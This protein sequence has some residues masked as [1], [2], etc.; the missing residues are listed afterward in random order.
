MDMIPEMN[1]HI[2][3]SKFMLP[4]CKAVASHT[5]LYKKKKKRLE[6]W[7][8][9]EAGLNLMGR[10]QITVF[11]P[12]D[13]NNT[14]TLVCPLDWRRYTVRSKPQHLALNCNSSL[15]AVID[16]SGVLTVLD[17]E[18]K[19]SDRSVWSLCEF[20]FDRSRV[21]PQKIQ[22]VGVIHVLEY[23]IGTLSS[24]KDLCETNNACCRPQPHSVLST[25]LTHTALTFGVQKLPPW[26]QVELHREKV[27]SGDLKVVQYYTILYAVLNH[28]LTISDVYTCT[29]SEQSDRRHVQVGNQHFE[30]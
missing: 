8:H 25:P 26:Y 22:Q 13:R 15:A 4:V 19:A 10:K 1:I 28:W 17:L 16:A 30:I 24:E 3:G 29:Y 18:G 23:S 11:F 9:F 7:R 2:P 21:T 6:S 20:L 14:G 27:E 5:L 12:F